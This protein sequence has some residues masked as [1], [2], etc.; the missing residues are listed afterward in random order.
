MENSYK[1]NLEY[2][3]KTLPTNPGVYQFLDKDGKVIYVGKAKNLKNRVSSYFREKNQTGKTR[4]LVSNIRDLLF[5][6]VNTE[7]DALLLENRLIKKFQPRYNILLKDDKTYPWICITNEDFPRVFFTRQKNKDS[8]FYFG[9]YTNLYSMKSILELIR[10]MFKL[11][12][13]KFSISQENIQK[14]KYEVCLDYHIHNCCGVCIGD[15]PKGIYDSY[16]K[17]VKDILGG[18]LSQVMQ[19]MENQMMTL[20][21][22]YQFEEA[23]KI[24]ERLEELK[25]YHAKNVI[26]VSIFNTVEVYSILEDKVDGYFYVNFMKVSNSIIIRSFTREFKSRLD[27]DINDVLSLAFAEIHFSSFNI[28]DDAQEIIFP[29]EPNFE[30]ENF[31]ITV[32]NQGDRKKL[33]DWSTHNCELYML[34]QNRQRSLTDPDKSANNIMKTMQKDLQMDYEPRH[35]E[36][37]DNSNIQGTN[38]V[39]SCVVFRD[40][41]PYKKDYRKYNVKTVEGPDDFATMREVIFRRYSRLLEEN[42]ELPHLIIV[43]GGKGQLRCAKETLE[44]LGI[45]NKVTVIG[46]AKRLEEIFFPD[47]NIPLYLDKNSVTLKV[48]QHLRDEAH[49]FGI[50]FHRQKRSKAMINSVLEE[51]D[52]IG[53]KTIEKLIKEF[54]SVKQISQTEIID[55]K[56]VVNLDKAVKIYDF[57]H[58]S[59]DREVL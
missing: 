23:Q 43:D 42:Q 58:K 37:F 3:V 5:I 1:E 12:T 48:I 11:R 36:C 29:F 59:N 19:A 46:I 39:S 50:T 44:Q 49:R 34:E 51:I 17:N 9:P 25:N 56:K 8:N 2:K 22:S 31:K 18:R 57:F 26:S 20:A 40:G 33:L 47:D 55:L 53:S 6:V 54:G 7:T 32:P 4:V 45:L 28:G 24:K 15:V 21:S 10:R 30:I 16:I 27:E 38:P 52:G 14:G 13:C 41:K 35:I